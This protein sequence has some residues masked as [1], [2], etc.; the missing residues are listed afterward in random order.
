MS[1]L[2]IENVGGLI[3]RQDK[4]AQTVVV[5]HRAI[6]ICGR[7][8]KKGQVVTVSGEDARVLIGLGRA[9]MYD[10][11]VDDPKPAAPAKQDKPEK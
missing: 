7:S 10:P 8:F 11:S 5:T 4:N 9:R 6:F 3:G 2:S 1:P